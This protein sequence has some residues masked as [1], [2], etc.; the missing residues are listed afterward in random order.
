MLIKITN[1][2]LLLVEILLNPFF[3]H[4]F[5][6]AAINNINSNAVFH[7]TFTAF[8]YMGE[9]IYTIKEAA[10]LATFIATKFIKSNV[11]FTEDYNYLILRLKRSKTDIKHEGVSIMIAAI[12]DGAC[13]VAALHTL[14]W[15]DP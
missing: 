14:F 6:S 8:L 15:V 12:G 4:S 2:G 7:F 9:F 11:C 13:L 3:T 10:D 5:N 1:V